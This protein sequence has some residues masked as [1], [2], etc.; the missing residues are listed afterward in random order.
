M[1]SLLITIILFCICFFVNCK[2]EIP[3]SPSQLLEDNTSSPVSKTSKS[4]KLIVEQETTTPPSSSSSNNIAYEALEVI[5]K[6][7][8]SRFFM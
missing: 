5:D 3:P 4:T 2:K 1:R 7:P 8:V 6:S